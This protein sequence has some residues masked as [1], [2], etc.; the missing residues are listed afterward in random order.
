MSSRVPSNS[1]GPFCCDTNMRS[2]L[3]HCTKWKTAVQDP[4]IPPPKCCLMWCYHLLVL[5]HVLTADNIVPSGAQCCLLIAQIWFQVD[6]TQWP[7]RRFDMSWTCFGSASGFSERTNHSPC[8]CVTIF[9]RPT[10]GTCDGRKEGP[11]GRN[12]TVKSCVKSTWN[13]N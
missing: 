13:N 10:S 9:G 11:Q 7:R 8:C 6:A 2:P 1:F 3:D 12:R 5:L 4:S